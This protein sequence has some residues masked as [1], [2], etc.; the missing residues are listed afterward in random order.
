[1][2]VRQM[3]ESMKLPCNY[4]HDGYYLKDSNEVLNQVYQSL[5]ELEDDVVPVMVECGGHDGITKSQSLKSSICLGM[6]TLL[7]EASPINYK[8][9]K[10]TRKYDF[11]VNAALCSGDSVE[12]VELDDNSGATHVV[13]EGEE[14]KGTVSVKCTTLDAEL[15]KLRDMLPEGQRDKLQLIFLVLDIETH[16]V[17]AIDSI[18]KYSPKKAL[19]EAFVRTPED[20]KKFDAWA[21]KHNLT[22]E[23]CMGRQDTC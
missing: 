13:R 10:Q 2:T 7:I 18:Q 14:K 11:T 3:K 16:E 1:L 19:M 4:V 9:L 20:T 8:V 15:D 21:Q 5:M 12:M 17:F 6:N 23:H 22:G